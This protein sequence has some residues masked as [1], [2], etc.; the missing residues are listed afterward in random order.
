MTDTA[1]SDTFN[2]IAYE[3]NGEMISTLFSEG[4]TIT[5]LSLENDLPPFVY[6]WLFLSDFL[7]TICKS[8]KNRGNVQK[9]R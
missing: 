5:S 8:K 3:R 7:G 1:K 2:C 9:H 6:S 4:E